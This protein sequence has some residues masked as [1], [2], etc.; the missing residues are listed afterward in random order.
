MSHLYQRSIQVEKAPDPTVRHFSA[1]VRQFV[2]LPPKT[3]VC[4]GISTTGRSPIL[5]PK[6]VSK[7]QIQDKTG[8]ETKK[9]PEKTNFLG[10]FFES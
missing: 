1:I 9:E 2:I 8:L 4:P 6:Q 5:F 7:C 3:V 10:H